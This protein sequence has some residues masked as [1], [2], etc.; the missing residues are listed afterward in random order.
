MIT[1]TETAP[2][3]REM[4]EDE[5][6]RERLLRHG[7]ETLSDAELL[8][9]LLRTGR[10][11]LPVMGLARELLEEMGGL[12]GMPGLS[13][14]DLRRE[15]LGQAKAASLLAAFE[16]AR[17]LAREQLPQRHL[18]S[19]PAAVANYL[20][21]RYRQRDQEVMGALFLDARHRLLGERDFF[22]G[23]LQRTSV[24]PRA[25]LREALARGA[26]GIL[27]FHTHPS[28]DPTPSN[29]DLLFTRRMTQA[30]D[31]LGVHLVDHLVLG[32]STRW[33]SLRQRGAC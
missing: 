23:T 30:C 1:T 25:I 4:A 26:A 16:I 12:N 14:S 17:R 21:L 18:M 7:S 11:G 5:R 2:P 15:G 28:G 10:P 33:V 22:R 27:L 19:R 8:A 13:Y 9:V 24:E 20:L 6:P 32:D 31:V 3:M 29:E